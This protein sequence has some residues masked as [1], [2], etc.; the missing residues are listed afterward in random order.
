MSAIITDVEIFQSIKSY[1]W[2]LDMRGSDLSNGDQ[3]DFKDA[4]FIGM[5]LTGCDLKGVS[6]ERCV[7]V[8][9]KGG[10]VDYSSFSGCF[11]DHETHENFESKKGVETSGTYQIPEL[12]GSVTLKSSADRISKFHR[13]PTSRR[14]CKPRIVWG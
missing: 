6:F 12:K 13:R 7:F 2:L 3:G 14:T 5:D 8:G 10:I 1:G 4:Q 9:C 11:I